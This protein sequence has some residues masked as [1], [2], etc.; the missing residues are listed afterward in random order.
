[1]YFNAFCE[2]RILEKISEFT[3]CLPPVIDTRRY[4]FVSCYFCKF[5]FLVFTIFVNKIIFIHSSLFSVKEDG[6][7][8]EY[9]VIYE[10][11]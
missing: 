7:F 3:V 4:I 6:N 2:N 8:D 11:Y 9:Y 10:R 5:I 1:M